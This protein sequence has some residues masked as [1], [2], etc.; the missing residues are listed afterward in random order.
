MHPEDARRRGLESGQRVQVASRVG[1]VE[2][3]L[4]VSEE[5]RPGVVSLPHGWGHGREG[6]SLRVANA[7]PGVSLNGLTD[8]LRV[9]PLSGNAAFSA[10]RVEV[11]R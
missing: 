8:D 5:M 4:E 11:T 9:D 2:A 3:A 6:T 10:V 1:S 7:V